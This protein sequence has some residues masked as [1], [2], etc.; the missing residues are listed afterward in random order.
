MDLTPL[1]HDTRCMSLARTLLRIALPLALAACPATRA[2]VLDAVNALRRAGC[3][4]AAGPVAPVQR[5]AALD[6]A[7]RRLAAGAEIGAAL[8]DAGYRADGAYAAQLTGVRADTAIGTLLAREH[9]ARLL[10]GQWREAGS[11][12]RGD[13]AWVLLAARADAP[14]L[15]DPARTARRVLALVNE[16]RARRRQCG[17]QAFAAAAP[18]GWSGTLAAAARSHALDMERHGFFDHRGSDGSGPLA[19]ITRAGYAALATGEN[20]A[21][22]QES[23]EEVVSGW[24]AS[25]HHCTNLMNPQFAELGLAYVLSR[26]RGQPI[27]WALT[28]GRQRP[29]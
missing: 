29:P 27:Y 21:F 2:D 15:A 10:D 26:R 5:H 19:R 14:D 18:L 22:N 8:A 25:P 11:F 1:G 24:L 4:G 13:S 28:L 6:A 23:A 17:T 20:L 12:Q 16:A 3:G 7:A 9:C